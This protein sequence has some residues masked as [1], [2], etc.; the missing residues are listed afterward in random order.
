MSPIIHKVPFILLAHMNSSDT[1]RQKR[2]LHRVFV[3]TSHTET[4]HNNGIMGFPAV[5]SPQYDITTTA[6]CHC[7]QTLTRSKRDCGPFGALSP[8]LFV[9]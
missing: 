2:D 5:K 3:V 1:Q 7:A 6:R 8:D 9:T 4:M